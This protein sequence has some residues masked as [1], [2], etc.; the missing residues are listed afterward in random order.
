MQEWSGAKSR[1]PYGAWAR[2]GKRSH[3][4]CSSENV[5]LELPT[6]TATTTAAPTTTTTT[7]TAAPTTTTT[8]LAAVNAYTCFAYEPCAKNN[9]DNDN[10][11]IPRN[12]RC[13]TNRQDT[14]QHR[15]S[16][17]VRSEVE[18]S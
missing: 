1:T 3:A 10:Y 17:V 9:N 11:N 13:T 8:A 5:A 15:T 6:T 14:S 4:C 18:L 12:S 2:Y 7:A 16:E